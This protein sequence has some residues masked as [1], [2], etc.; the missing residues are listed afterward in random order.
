MIPLAFNLL[1]GPK[2]IHFVYFLITLNL[3]YA[4]TEKG[5]G[6]G[7]GIW[8]TALV[9]TITFVPIF[10]SWSFIEF[11]LTAYTV[12]AFW[13]SLQ[14]LE[15][16]RMQRVSHALKACGVDRDQL[17]SDGQLQIYCAGDAGVSGTDGI[18]SGAIDA[19]TGMETGGSSHTGADGSS[20]DAG[21]A[22]VCQELALVWK[23]HVSIC[24]ESVSHTGMVGV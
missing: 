11:G 18:R 24:G 5:I 8:G 21:I 15:E 2:L 17:G 4:L 13:F 16:C 6:R 22:L 10:A 12:L 14:V 7:G 9:A 1:S 20:R 3:V 19:D 23:S